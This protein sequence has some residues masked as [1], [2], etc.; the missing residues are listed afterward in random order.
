MARAVV[1]AAMD[2]EG[3]LFSDAGADAV[4]AFD[5]FGPDA[6]EP[7]APT[8]EIVG[9]GFVAAM[10]NGDSLVV[11]QEDDVALLADDGVETIDLFP[12]LDNDFGDGF[13][14]VGGGADV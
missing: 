5:L 11:A 12:C 14:G 13:F 8:L 9:P 7:D 6:A 2:E 10:V 1:L 4:G 3:A